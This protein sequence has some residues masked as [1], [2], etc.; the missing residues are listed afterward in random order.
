MPI[1]SLNLFFFSSPVVILIKP[2]FF[3]FQVQK[4]LIGVHLMNVTVPE[5]TNHFKY[6]LWRGPS[7]VIKRL[8][9]SNADACFLVVLYRRHEMSYLASECHRMSSRCA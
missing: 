4:C 8:K 6:I 9:F 5:I 7:D 1:E 2:H 3:I